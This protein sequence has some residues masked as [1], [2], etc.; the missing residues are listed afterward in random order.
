MYHEEA[1]WYIIHVSHFVAWFNTSLNFFW[2]KDTTN[3]VSI[4][5]FMFFDIYV[6]QCLYQR[7]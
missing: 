2:E 6:E 4:Q 3:V 7:C 1:A 5:I